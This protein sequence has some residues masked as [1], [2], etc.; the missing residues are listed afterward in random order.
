MY[1]SWQ[2]RAATAA[3]LLFA[4]VFTGPPVTYL[5]DVAVNGPRRLNIE[6]FFI[7]SG[8]Y[9]I[10]FLYFFLRSF[11]QRSMSFA[12]H[13]VCLLCG[14]FIWFVVGLMAHTWLTE[15][16]GAPQPIEDSIYGLAFVLAFPWV[17]TQYAVTMALASVLHLDSLVP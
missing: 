3:V 4:W 13:V 17:A 6:S 16:L 8:L 11:S 2:S 10:W 7:A 1:T 9:L 12:E 5:F 14:F 15:T